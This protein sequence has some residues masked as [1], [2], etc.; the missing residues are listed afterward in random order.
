MASDG[1]DAGNTG[2]TVAMSTGCADILEQN[3]EGGGRCSYRPGSRNGFGLE[4][5]I[6]RANKEPQRVD[7]CRWGVGNES[8]KN[9]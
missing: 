4:K 3:I 6:N 5:R 2:G 1:G 8:I 7:S 9:Q